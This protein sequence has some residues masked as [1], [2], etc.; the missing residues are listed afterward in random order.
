MTQEPAEPFR[1][2][3]LCLN[4]LFNNIHGNQVQLIT[5]EYLSDNREWDVFLLASQIRTQCEQL[6]DG[7]ALIQQ[8][9]A[10]LY[11]TACNAATLP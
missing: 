6:R 3:P 8:Y 5:T 1:T 2:G 10:H 9:D 7:Y 11:L 4:K